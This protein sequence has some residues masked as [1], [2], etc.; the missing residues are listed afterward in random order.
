MTEYVL[1]HDHD[2]TEE[3]GGPYT[4]YLTYLDTSTENINSSSV[5]HFVT[6]EEAEAHAV[7]T[8]TNSPFPDEC[9]WYVTEA[10]AIS[11]PR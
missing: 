4:V 1:A 8:N 10:P 3:G 2:D 5:L 11:V 9:N 7:L 6:R